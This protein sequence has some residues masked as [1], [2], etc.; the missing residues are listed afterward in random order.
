ME[1]NESLAYIAGFVDG[2]GS[3]GLTN[4]RGTCSSVIVQ[5]V[6]TNSEVM[7]Y[8]NAC[9]PGRMYVQA[10]PGRKVIY[11]LY[12]QG[13]DAITVLEL[14]LPYLVV[15]RRIAELALEFWRSCIAYVD[16]DTDEPIPAPTNRGQPLNE[17][18]L[19]LRKS[20]CNRMQE[21]NR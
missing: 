8:I 17:A 3:V 12:W 18:E 9:L 5:L 1:S 14:L 4:P 10:R 15:K 11:R 21:L 6:N 20:Y 7:Y 2:E 13:Q 19:I 16:I